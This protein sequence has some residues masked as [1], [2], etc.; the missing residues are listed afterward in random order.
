[1]SIH[2]A[3]KLSMHNKTLLQHH[4]TVSCYGCLKIFPTKEIKE[5]TDKNTTAICP[6]CHCDTI[7]PRCEP[8]ALKEIKNYWL[9][10]AK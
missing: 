2:E 6:Y 1:M 8:N 9:T 4:P 7:I 3:P 5:W 10:P